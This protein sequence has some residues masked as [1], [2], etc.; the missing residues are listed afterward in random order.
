[1]WLSL[2]QKEDTGG[3]RQSRRSGVVSF[4]KNQQQHHHHHHHRW[5]HPSHVLHFERSLRL[6][7]AAVSALAGLSRSNMS[8]EKSKWGMHAK[9]VQ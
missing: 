5:C 2:L 6:A 4:D 7:S 9:Q 1:M 8:G 3:S